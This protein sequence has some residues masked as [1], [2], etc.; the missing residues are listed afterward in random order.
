MLGFYVPNAFTPNGD[1]K[2]DVFR[3]SLFGNV[4]SYLFCIYNRFGELVFKT[5]N[6]GEGWD[7]NY[8]GKPFDSGTTFVWRCAY[9]L[10]GDKPVSAKGYVVLIK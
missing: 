8:K 5:N 3:P 2:N 9:Q 10:Q 1:G 7:G 6:P 4:Q